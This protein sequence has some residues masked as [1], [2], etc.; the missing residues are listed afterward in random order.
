MKLPVLPEK[1]NSGKFIWV[2]AGAIIFVRAGWGVVLT[3]DQ[4][5]LIITT[6]VFSYFNKKGKEL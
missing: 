6:V 2:I 1:L 5:F 3:A 4:I